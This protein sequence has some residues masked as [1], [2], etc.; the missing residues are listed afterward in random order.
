MCGTGQREGRALRRIVT[1]PL[2]APRAWRR[3]RRRRP[4]G[5]R[6]VPAQIAANR[7]DE[8]QLPAI[9]TCAPLFLDGP[10]GTHYHQAQRWQLETL[11]TVWLNA[12]GAKRVSWTPGTN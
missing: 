5:Y 1:G 2:S 12:A 11:V 9:S 3:H 6:R 7:G 10:G 4:L 8:A